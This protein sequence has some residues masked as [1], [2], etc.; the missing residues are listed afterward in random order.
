M[1]DKFADMPPR[2]RHF[3][4]VAFSPSSA[5]NERMKALCEV[6]QF[7]KSIGADCYEVVARVEK[8][9]Q[10]VLPAVIQAKIK[11][12]FDAGYAKRTA[13]EV[14]QR[15]RAVAVVTSLGGFD[16]NGHNGFSWREIAGH[17]FLNRHRIRNDWEANK[18]LPSVAERLASPRYALSEKEAPILRRIFQTWFNG[19]I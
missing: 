1:A 19:Q 7:L 17:C 16:P 18:F 2:V 9:L 14:E 13:E 12:A 11:E 8:P 6:D 10:P 5:P 15:Q 3:W 4:V